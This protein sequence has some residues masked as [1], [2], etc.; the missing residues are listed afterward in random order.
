M[1]FIL[2]VLNLDLQW[3]HLV[4]SISLIHCAS[5][6][7]PVLRQELQW[8]TQRSLQLPGVSWSPMDSL[9]ETNGLHLKIDGWK[10]N[11]YWNSSFSGAM[12]VSGR[13]TMTK[14]KVEPLSNN[15]WSCM[16]MYDRALKSSHFLKTLVSESPIPFIHNIY[17]YIDI[18][19]YIHI[20]SHN[21]DWF[22]TE[23]SN[24]LVEQKSNKSLYHWMKVFTIHASDSQGCE[25]PL[26][27]SCPD[28]VRVAWIW[29]LSA[30][31]ITQ[32]E[33]GYK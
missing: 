21:S 12:L 5:C 14:K 26:R 22:V 16:I 20:P 6:N 27:S 25:A 33:F 17:I 13:V 11:S 18:Y 23:G 31:D 28:H 4:P 19:I 8:W 32:V 9:P 1:I 29:G 7:S 10:M 3:R 15:F 2:I 30:I 24:I